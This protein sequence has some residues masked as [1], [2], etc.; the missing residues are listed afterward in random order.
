MTKAFDTIMEGLSDVEAYL[1]GERAGFV[2]HIPEKVDVRA[3]RQRLH[4]SQPKFAEAFGFSVGRIRDW[5]QGRFPVDTSSRVLLTVI[6]REP[7][8]VL[9]ALNQA[10]NLKPARTGSTTT[11]ATK[12]A[13]AAARSARPKG[14]T[15]SL[16][17]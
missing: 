2:V 7:E 8:A 5:E 3:I 1:S 6:D 10:Q 17:R 12:R 14:R 13:G 4:L 9:R 16:T 15:A 11:S